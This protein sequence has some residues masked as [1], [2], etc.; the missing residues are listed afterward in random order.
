MTDQIEK[1][2]DKIHNEYRRLSR[3][4]IEKIVRQTVEEIRRKD[5]ELLA[6]SVAGT[7]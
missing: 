5:D 3:S 4:E 7:E 1:I 6:N 2:I